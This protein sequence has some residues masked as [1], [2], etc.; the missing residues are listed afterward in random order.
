M[1]ELCVLIPAHNEAQTIG[2]VVEAV[3]R[4]GYEAVVIDDGSTDS[5]GDI[6]RQKG[7]VVISRSG[8]RG[9]GRSLRSGF[10]HI[11]RQD[12]PAVIVMDADGQHDAGD[13]EKFVAQAR[14][15][16]RSVIVGNRMENPRGMP[17]VRYLTNRFMSTLISRACRQDIPDTQCGYRYIDCGILRELSLRC[18]DFEIESE[19]LMKAAQKGFPIYSVPIK[20]IY[21]NEESK[22]RPLKDTIRFFVY[23]LREILTLR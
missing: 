19:I 2:G 15:Q 10:D 4:Q 23:F 7:A 9:K 21:E 1:P 16:P 22:I 20:T 6:A 14:R 13:I 18:D 11:L 12:Y 17:W 5:T 8:K 3:K